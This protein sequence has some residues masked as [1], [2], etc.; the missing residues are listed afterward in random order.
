M[1]LT[2]LRELHCPSFHCEGLEGANTGWAW[3]SQ[4]ETPSF[5]CAD[6]RMWGVSS[7]RAETSLPNWGDPNLEVFFNVS[8][9]GSPLPPLGERRGQTQTWRV[10]AIPGGKVGTAPRSC[11]D[12][13]DLCP[14]SLLGW[15]MPQLLWFSARSRL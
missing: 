1:F 4:K 8:P 6:I 5:A 9:A 2:I 3:H 13:G 7:E 15:K 12:Q 11:R 14:P 10:R